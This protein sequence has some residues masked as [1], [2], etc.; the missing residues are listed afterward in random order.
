M[1]SSFSFPTAMLAI[2][3]FFHLELISISNLSIL[4]AILSKSYFA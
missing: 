1:H 4:S 3:T 2:S